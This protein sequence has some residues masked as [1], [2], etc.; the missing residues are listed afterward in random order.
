VS[1]LYGCTVQCG[2]EHI[3]YVWLVYCRS[4]AGLLPAAG[5]NACEMLNSREMI[6]REVDEIMEKLGFVCILLA[7]HGHVLSAYMASQFINRLK[8]QLYPK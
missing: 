8:P 4:F 3:G 2:T 7:F 1:W 5:S 6:C